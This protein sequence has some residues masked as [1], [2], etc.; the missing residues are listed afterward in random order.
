MISYVLLGSAGL[1]KSTLTGHVEYDRVYVI[2]G[3]AGLGK[4]MLT[5]HFDMIVYVLLGSEN[6][7]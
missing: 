2:L 6:L 5:G 3:S 7:L 4:Y 1:E